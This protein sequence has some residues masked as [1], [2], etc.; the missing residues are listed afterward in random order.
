M[1]NL[2]KN[3]GRSPA[4]DEKYDLIYCSGLFDY[5]NDR[6]IKAINA[7]LYDRLLPGGLL[8]A[9]NFAPNNPIRNLM[10]HTLEWFLIYR[11]QAQMTALAPDEASA[12]D[13]EIKMEP[14][15]T[16]IFLEVRKPK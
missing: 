10:E 1:Q 11:D 6:L 9:G 4:E 8:V 7:Y 3:A 15:G 13:C 5:L 12:A 2:L 16:N 14:S